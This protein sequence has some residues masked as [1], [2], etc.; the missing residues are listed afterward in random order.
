MANQRAPD[1]KAFSKK[2]L[3]TGKYSDFTISCHGHEWKVHRAILGRVKL[4]D[5]LFV[6]KQESAIRFNKLDDHDP[7]LVARAILFIYTGDYRMVNITT[8]CP[9]FANIHDTYSDIEE[10]SY[11]CT[12][13]LN[14]ALRLH[15]HLYAFAARYDIKDLKI[16]S[17]RRFLRD[18]LSEMPS[19]ES[20]Y[21]D[22]RIARDLEIIPDI[23]STTPTTDRGLRNIVLL[24][25]KWYLESPQ[26]DEAW[27]KDLFE[28]VPEL[29]H[30][31]ENSRLRYCKWTCRVCGIAE[32]CPDGVKMCGTQPSGE[33]QPYKKLRDCDECANP[34]TFCASSRY[35]I[36][37][38]NIFAAR[39]HTS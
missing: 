18:Y 11:R 30:E 35:G 20:D 4:F 36:K 15:I 22:M 9:Q 26:F 24:A 2:L 38:P 33:V 37:G 25:I 21:N 19:D 7:S 13:G 23:Y 3:A 31:V 14:Q 34:M 28:K 27:L 32:E 5:T 12:V 29:R 6:Q 1:D 10:H 17:E 8:A 39:M 16:A